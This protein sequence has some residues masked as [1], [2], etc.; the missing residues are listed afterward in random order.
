MKRYIFESLAELQ[1]HNEIIEKP[2]EVFIPATTPIHISTVTAEIEEPQETVA[3]Q[4][5]DYHQVEIDD[6]KKHYEDKLKIAED[7]KDLLERIAVNIGMIFEEEQRRKTTYPP[8]I[9]E[10]IVSIAKKIIG[11]SFD[12]NSCAAIE[13]FLLEANK[14]IAS[15]NIL[16]ITIP[17]NLSDYF[18][19][20]FPATQIIIDE[21]LNKTDCLIKW[22]K[23]HI[24]RS[25]NE[26][27]QEIIVKID[28]YFRGQL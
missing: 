2:I 15:E 7:N 18:V 23:G 9:K 19:N 20:K 8:F 16:S 3:E 21:N 13:D 27:W 10:I 5:V 24:V 22:Q 6:L 12:E 11:K 1:E 4:P 28:E 25:E 26:I 14:V 17:P